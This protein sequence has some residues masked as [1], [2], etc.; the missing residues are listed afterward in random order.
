MDPSRLLGP[1]NRQ[2]KNKGVSCHVLL[3]EIFLTQ[4]WNLCPL[5]WQV[6]SLPLSYQ[7]RPKKK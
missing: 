2:G 5:H 3:Q 4:E 1:W 6:N 7:G